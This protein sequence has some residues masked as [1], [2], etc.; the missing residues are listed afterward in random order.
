MKKQIALIL[1]LALCLAAFAGCGSEAADPGFEAVAEAVKSAV[2]TGS[3]AEQ[4]SAYIENMI[5]LASG[6]YEQALVM[7]TNMGTSIDE[8]GLF[9]AAGEEQVEGIHSAIDAYLEHRLEGWM[10]YQPEE[11]PKLQNAQV[12]TEGNYVLYLILSEDVKAAASSA[13]TGCFAG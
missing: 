1:A 7:V 4:D 6:S 3:M 12:F 5:G 2:G 11:L 10:P 8:F 9:K 13:F